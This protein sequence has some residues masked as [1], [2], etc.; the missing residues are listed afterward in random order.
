MYCADWLIWECMLQTVQ[1]KVMEILS[2][3]GFNL[4]SQENKP[5]TSTLAE[6]T[7][8]KQVVS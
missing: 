3:G 5:Y 7:V 6:C 4:I 8:S 2:V 1:A